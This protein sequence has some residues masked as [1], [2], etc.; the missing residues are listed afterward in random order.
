MMLSNESFVLFRLPHKNKVQLW[1]LNHDSEG[2][3]TFI[4]NSFDNQH[5]LNLYATQA[6]TYNLEELDQI[7]LDLTF[8]SDQ[9]IPNALNQEEYLQKAGDFIQKLNHKDFDKIILSRV[10]L[11]DKID[12]L[13]ERFIY[14]CQKYP[15]AWVYLFHHQKEIWLGASPEKLLQSTPNGYQTVA[16]AG[17]KSKLDHRDW[18]PKEYKEHQFVVDYI[19]SKFNAQ[20]IEQKGPYTIDLGDIQHLKTAIEITDKSLNLENILIQLHPT[21][22]VCGIPKDQ[23]MDYIIENEGYN[24]SFYTGYFGIKTPNY[25][26]FYVNL[27]CAQLFQNHTALYV[28][29]GLVAESNAIAEWNETELKARALL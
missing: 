28:G 2:E 15:T 1:L 10:K 6:Y 24:R 26:S 11:V 19:A 14:L 25:T 20:A 21:P 13:I 7:K 9:E 8:K 12:D 17:T 5:K 16:L 23:T 4:F 3:N 27:R 18:T 22:A 29:G